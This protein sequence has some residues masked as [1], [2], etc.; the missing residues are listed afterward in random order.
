MSQAG[1]PTIVYILPWTGVA[2][3][4]PAVTWRM[5][6]YTCFSPHFSMNI[7]PLL[8]IF[9]RLVVAAFW[10]ISMELHRTYGLS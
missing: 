4:M 8:D 2:G 6:K 7:L 5:N 10:V 9:G 1:F 3:M